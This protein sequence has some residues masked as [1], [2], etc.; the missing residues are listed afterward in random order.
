MQH[1]FGKSV[2]ALENVSK[3]YDIFSTMEVKRGLGLVYLTRAM[4]YRSMAESWRENGL[5]LDKAVENV[6]LAIKD[7]VNA[8]RI[9]KESV[10][11]TIRY[12][13]A[14]N[15]MGSCYRCLYL[16][17]TF[18]SA[19]D[20]EKSSILK[21]GI[22]YYQQAI[23]NAQKYEYSIDELDSRQD[24]AV[25]YFRA[26]DY[27]KASGELDKIDHVIPAAYKIKPVSGLD[28]IPETDTVDA[29]YKLMGQIESLRAAMIFESIDGQSTP[30][31]QV[32]KA[33]EHYVL[34]IAYYHRF[35]PSSN[36]HVRT[37][38]RIY[39]RLRR[40]D[41]LVLAEIQNVH[42][43]E[44]ITKY[45]IPLAWVEPLFDQVFEMLRI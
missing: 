10:Q 45:Q 14:L 23:T 31:E 25:L 12:V 3:A 38:D 21:E 39:K 1:R 8:I 26:Q 33:I 19:D 16:L 13:F 9:F 20:H 22:D 29:Y 44:W 30:T 34:G 43:K 24:M 5:N 11:E 37:A 7:L 2:Q 28:A 18:G 17:R 40:C 27:K 35:S 32:L 6:Q 4:I 42:L 36:T 15:E 41:K